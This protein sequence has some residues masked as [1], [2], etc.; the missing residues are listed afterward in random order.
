MPCVFAKSISPISKAEGCIEPRAQWRGLNFMVERTEFGQATSMPS[1][2]AFC[3]R[4]SFGKRCGAGLKILDRMG[5]IERATQLVC[6][7]GRQYAR[8]RTGHDRLETAYE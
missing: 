4:F 2:L 5:V 1:L 6:K 3:R 7:R 8:T